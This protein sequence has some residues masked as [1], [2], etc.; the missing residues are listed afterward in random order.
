MID[1]LGIFT[2]IDILPKA[3]VEGYAKKIPIKNLWIKS[4]S[5]QGVLNYSGIFRS[6]TG[7]YYSFSFMTNNNNENIKLK[8]DIFEV[9]RQ[10]IK[11]I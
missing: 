4:G 2:V 10:L 6:K 11:Y 9:I 5:I 7:K 8:A 3:G 1:K